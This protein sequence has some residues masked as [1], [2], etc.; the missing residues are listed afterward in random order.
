MPIKSFRIVTIKST[1]KEMK[2]LNLSG[3]IWIKTKFRIH[4]HNL[5]LHV[6][7]CEWTMHQNIFP[8]FYAIICVV[9]CKSIVFILEYQM[10]WALWNGYMQIQRRSSGGSYSVH[11]HR[12]VSVIL[13][14]VQS[15]HESTCVFK[16]VATA[17]GRTALRAL[18]V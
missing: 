14:Q 12:L 3:L 16:L 18:H 8:N 1:S 15:S 13:A 6:I 9:T 10:A 11:V 7:R 2:K 5:D 17:V 4:G